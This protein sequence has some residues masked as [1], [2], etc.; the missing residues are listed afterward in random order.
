MMKIDLAFAG[1]EKD[2]FKMPMRRAL[3][4]VSHQS[5][6]SGKCFPFRPIFRDAGADRVANLL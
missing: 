4:V 1:E 2:V 6:K 5:K 3:S